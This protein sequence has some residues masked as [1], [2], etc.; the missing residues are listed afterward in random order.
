MKSIHLS[1]IT[2]SFMEIILRLAKNV[3]YATFLITCSQ[4]APVYT[5]T[6][7]ERGF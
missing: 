7:T 5:I 2:F 1:K 6:Q 4:I 3:L